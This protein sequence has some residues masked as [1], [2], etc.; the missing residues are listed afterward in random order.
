MNQDGSD[1]SGASSNKRRHRWW[2]CLTPHRLQDLVRKTFYPR[3]NCAL[4]Y[5]GSCYAGA[6]GKKY[7]LRA[8]PTIRARQGFSSGG[9]FEDFT[10]QAYF[11]EGNLGIQRGTVRRYCS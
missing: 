11:A 10:L 3:E 5:I 8:A 9:I 1:A 4:F 7:F 6:V 2:H